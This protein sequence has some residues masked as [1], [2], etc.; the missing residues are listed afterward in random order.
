[1]AVDSTLCRGH[2]L[3]ESFASAVSEVGDE[4]AAHVTEEHPVGRD[5][6]AAR[7]A[8]AMC[9]EQAISADE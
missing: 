5:A 6:A 1:V 9:S 8:V 3:C 4:D 2:A 7:Q